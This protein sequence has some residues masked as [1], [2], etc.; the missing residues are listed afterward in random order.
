MREP[1]VVQ[2]RGTVP[3]KKNSYTP[4]SRGK[5]F[6][7]SKSLQEAI[8][9]LALQIPAEV[10][11]LHLDSPDITFHFT[12]RKFNADRDNKVTCL[13]DVLVAYGVLADD[14]TLRCNGRITIEPAVRGEYD[15]VTITLVPRDSLWEE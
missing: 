14:N 3:S 6:F 9:R 15:S 13:L 1:I 11:D 2:F 7:K 10:R 4:R 5:G 12:F 8:D